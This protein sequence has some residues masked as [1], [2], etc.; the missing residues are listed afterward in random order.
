MS[1]FLFSL[2]GIPATAGFMGKL[3]LFL[4][5]LAVPGQA[6]LP[7]EHT[8]LFPMLAVL[9]AVTAAIG[10]YYYL[11]IVAAMYLRSPLRPRQ[12]PRSWP[13]VAAIAACAA[14]TI[15]FGVYP[16][17]LVRLARAAVLP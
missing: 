1:L 12:A 15:V 17:P 7:P 11:R 2:I 10:A 14:V 5:A 4:A 13:I 6:S 3:L 8:R 9:L 16:D